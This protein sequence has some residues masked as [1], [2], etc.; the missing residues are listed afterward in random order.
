M[1]ST[2]PDILQALLYAR[3]ESDALLDVQPGRGIWQFLNAF[4]GYLFRAHSWKLLVRQG[5]VKASPCHAVYYSN[6]TRRR[7]LSKWGT[8]F[9]LVYLTFLLTEHCH[10]RSRQEEDKSPAT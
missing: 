5:A 8:V 9:L 4:E 2:L 6:Q 10:K 1:G 7:E 3:D